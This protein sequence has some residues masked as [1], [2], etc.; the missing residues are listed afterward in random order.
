MREVARY[1]KPRTSRADCLVWISAGSADVL[2]SYTVN[3]EDPRLNRQFQIGKPL[4][5][6][7]T[8]VALK[9]RLLNLKVQVQLTESS[10]D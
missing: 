5:P 3:E 8:T 4:F 6:T 7:T 2:P 10:S 9:D 1:I